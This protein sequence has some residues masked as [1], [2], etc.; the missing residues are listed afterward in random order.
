MLKLL[1]RDESFYNEIERLS[2][3][4]QTTATVMDKLVSTFPSTNGLPQKI[5]QTRCDANKVVQDSLLRLDEAFI[6]PLDRED[7]ML[8]ITDLYSV[9]DRIA[10]VAERFEFFHLKQLYPNLQ[11][12]SETLKKSA[13]VLNDIIGHL[14]QDKKLPELSP[15]LDELHALQEQARKNRSHFLSELFTDKADPID[16][17]K[18]KELHDLL[19]GAIQGC[20]KVTQTLGRVMLKNG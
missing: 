19:E 3:I 11:E 12:Q 14:R 13:A 4:V 16:V 15:K 7:I 5:E 9:V 1:P 10:A 17:M 6:T 18:K 8:L 20:E 2:Q